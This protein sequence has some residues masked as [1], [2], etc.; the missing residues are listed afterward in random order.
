MI[1]IFGR[2]TRSEHT[3][4][5]S[6]NNETQRGQ[7]DCNSLML[8]VFHCFTA[9]EEKLGLDC[10]KKYLRTEDKIIKKIYFLI[11]DYI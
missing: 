6:F 4:L 7:T 2:N 10:R 1:Q 11:T 3:R 5:T 8:S 9:M